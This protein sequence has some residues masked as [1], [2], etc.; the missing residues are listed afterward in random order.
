MEHN[1]VHCVVVRG[2]TGERELPVQY[3]DMMSTEAITFYTLY[4]HI[5]VHH[6]S[7]NMLM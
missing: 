1:E 7:W 2:Q 6:W 5:Y 4:V 3:I